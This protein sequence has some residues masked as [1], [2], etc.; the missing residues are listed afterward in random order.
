M[1]T[2]DRMKLVHWPH[3]LVDLSTEATAEKKPHMS[4]LANSV[5]H[6]NAQLLARLPANSRLL[7]IG[8]GTYSLLQSRMRPPQLWEGID[9]ASTDR[10]GN[11]SIATRRASVQS[12][13][14]PSRSFDYVVSNQSIEHWHEYG[15]GISEGLAE[16][17]RV[18]TK[19]GRAILNFPVH[20]HGHQLFLQGSFEEIERIF[21]GAGFAVERRTAI[22]DSSHTRYQGWQLCGFPDFLVKK[23]PHHE[24][25]SYVVEYELRKVADESSR[26]TPPPVRAS[27]RISTGARHLHYGLGYM[28]WKIATH[29]VG[30]RQRRFQDAAGTDVT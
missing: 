2:L 7:E 11:P 25:T 29:L 28:A 14:W 21:L 1:R 6:L 17:N 5:E 18:L 15:V 30:R 10:K 20:L 23:H 19:D 4:V 13:P 9:V 26:D 12:I 8:C 16:I 27:S 22:I 24:D 3:D